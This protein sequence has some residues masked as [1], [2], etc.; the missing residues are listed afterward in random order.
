MKK[1]FILTLVAFVALALASCGPATDTTP[2]GDTY[3]SAYLP[4]DYEDA[5][6]V[7]SQLALG[8]LR[9]EGTTLAPT[10]DEALALLPLWQAL[11][12]LQSGGA[13]APEEV[14]AIL[15]QIE[16]SLR[17]EQLQEIAAMELTNADMQAWASE[18][19]MQAGTGEGSPGQGQGLSPEARAT[20]QAE[21]GVTSESAGGSRMS[22]ALIDAVIAFLQTINP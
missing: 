11:R 14:N 16:T 12:S 4:V 6:S 8:T 21:Q 1:I 7:R 9:L 22:S 10:S 18:N 17:P 3:V 15:A 5:I 13:S 2:T 20:K 19:G